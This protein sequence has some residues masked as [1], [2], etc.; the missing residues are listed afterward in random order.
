[1]LINAAIVINETSIFCDAVHLIYGPADPIN[2]QLL[3]R[4]R[5]VLR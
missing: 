3:Q 5:L 1:M 2:P 4:F